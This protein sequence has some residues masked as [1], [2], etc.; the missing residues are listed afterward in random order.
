MSDPAPTPPDSPLGA[1]PHAHSTTFRV[2]AP[3]ADWV[4][5]VGDFNGWKS[6]PMSGDDAGVWS[7]DIPGVGHGAQYKYEIR[8]GD[9][10]FHRIDPR[11]QHVTNSVGIGLVHDHSL[12]DWEGDDHHLPGFQDLV[13]YEAHVGTFND[14]PGGTPGTLLQASKKLDHVVSL[15]ANVIQLMPVAE[16]AGDFSWGYNPSHIFAVESAYGGPDA[17]KEFVKQ[18]HRRDLSVVIDVVYNHFGP[19][20]LDLW[21]FDG[22]S[23]NGLGGIYFYNDERAHTPWGDTRPDYGRR[24]VRDFILD[25]AR[26]WLRDYHADGLR[27]DMTPFIRSV[28]GSG[29]DLPDGWSLMQEVNGALREERPNL[30]TIA[31]DMH[32]DARITGW[33]SNGAGFSAQW[34]GRFVHPVR[35]ALTTY[36]DEDRS[37]GEVAEACS[38]IYDQ[39]AF[40]RVIYT[41]SHDEV[42]NGQS[43]MVHEVNPH[44]EHGWWAQKRSTLGA[45]LVMVSP[46]IPM[47]FQGQEFLEGG[48]FRDTVPLTWS[49]DKT[50]HGVVRLYRDLIQL[51]R[52]WHSTTT[53][54]KGHGVEVFHRNEE[55]KILAIHRWRDHGPGDD[56]VAVANLSDTPQEHYRIGL[57]TE[58]LWRLRLNTDARI[59]SE[60]FGDFASF[61]TSAT[62]PGQDGLPASGEIAIGPYTLLIYSQNPEPI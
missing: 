37:V 29:Y 15:G 10:T 58:G 47:L 17:L 35:E 2:W 1:T 46:G 26:M 54:L 45:A 12:F 56:V 53:G 6:T 39:D 61:D 13:I 62:S 55:A 49:Q 30:I 21:Q 7:V 28:D 31:E 36:R 41:E 57:P 48:W 25:N 18:C 38:L 44:D 5:V 22:W 59:Y 33:D 27:F 34:D 51:R 8:H 11:A 43:R 23:E 24:E 50:F 14:R 52:D 20:D 9:Q 32:G 16:F 19:S 3:N 40:R 60:I 42:A 4:G